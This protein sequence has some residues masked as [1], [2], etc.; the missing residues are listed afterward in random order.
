M[1]KLVSFLQKHAFLKKGMSF[2]NKKALAAASLAVRWESTASLPP[3]QRQPFNQPDKPSRQAK[4]AFQTIV[5][6][7]LQ[8]ACLPD[9]CPGSPP[10]SQ[11]SFPCSQASLPGSLADRQAAR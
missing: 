2:F 9:H 10:G 11:A 4:Q 3:S 8:A 6:A 7:V 5:Q 1:T